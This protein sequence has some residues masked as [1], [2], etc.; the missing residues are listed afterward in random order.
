MANVREALKSPSNAAVFSGRVG[1][2]E[3]AVKEVDKVIVEKTVQ[4]VFTD[5]VEAAAISDTSNTIEVEEVNGVE[6]KV[7][8]TVEKI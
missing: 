6:K 4:T 2:Q 1:I 3:P 7:T 5:V 8:N